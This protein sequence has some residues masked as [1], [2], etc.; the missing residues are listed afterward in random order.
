MPTLF[1]FTDPHGKTRNAEAIVEA[2]QERGVDGVLASGDLTYFGSV[3]QQF[4]SRLQG[5]NRPIYCIPGNHEDDE[6]FRELR[7]WHSF[8]VD[9]SYKVV[10][11]GSF[12][13][14]GIPGSEE[15]WWPD[16][17]VD[18]DL[19]EQTVALLTPAKR[20]K[21]FILLVHIPPSG[22]GLDGTKYP[23]PDAGGNATAG[24]VIKRL[25]P[26]LVITGHYHQHFGETG[27]LDGILIEN[28]GPTGSFLEAVRVS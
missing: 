7:M 21:P 8:W 3:E 27:Q 2:L 25:K 18:Q 1:A 4:C 13:V 26:D 17:R 22:C 16:L 28:P 20:G 15:S 9:V 19:L 11:A 10:D 24:E 6:R 5:L 14:G 12:L 23:T